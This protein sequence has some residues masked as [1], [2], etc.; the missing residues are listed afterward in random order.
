MSGTARFQLA[1]LTRTGPAAFS[2]ESGGFGDRACVGVRDRFGRERDH[3]QDE[4]E[5]E[6]ALDQ[7][8]PA[9]LFKSTCE[10]PHSSTAYPPLM[11]LAML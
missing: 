7:G 6:Q 2:A 8:L 10:R 4:A 5:R 1:G 9:L 3:E 11:K